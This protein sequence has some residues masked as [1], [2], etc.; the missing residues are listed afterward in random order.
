MT[1]DLPTIVL[2]ILGAYAMVGLGV[3]VWLAIHGFRRFGSAASTASIGARIA[4]VPGAALLWP[5][6]VVLAR[7]RGSRGLNAGGGGEP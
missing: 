5:V 1:D 3:A 2:L 4:W 7:R 6:V